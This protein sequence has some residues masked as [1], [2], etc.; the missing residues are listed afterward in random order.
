M[1]QFT[2]AIVAILLSAA[3]SFAQNIEKDWQ[4]EASQSKLELININLSN[5]DVLSIKE[6][7][8]SYNKSSGDYIHQ[9][10]VL[11]RKSVV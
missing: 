3:S 7:T 9:N 4:L 10:N 11:D 1:K 8:F 2:L 6:G 5:K